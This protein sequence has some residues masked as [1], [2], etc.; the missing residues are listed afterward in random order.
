MS[1]ISIDICKKCENYKTN[2]TYFLGKADFVC[3][4]INNNK[5]ISRCAS[6]QI[7]MKKDS[8]IPSFCLYKLEHLLKGK[9]K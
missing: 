7:G 9:Q 6:L 3:C 1:K 8:D 5:I 4:I 2:E